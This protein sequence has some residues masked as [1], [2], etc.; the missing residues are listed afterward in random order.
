MIPILDSQRKETGRFYKTMADTILP[1]Y[2]EDLSIDIRSPNDGE[3]KTIPVWRFI[4]RY[5]RITDKKGKFIPFEMKLAQI[6]LYKELCLQKRAGKNMRINILKAR[7]LG[8][9]TFIAALYTVLTLLVPNQSAVIVADLAQHATNIFKKYKFMYYNLPQSIKDTIPLVAS[10]AKEVTVDYGNGQTSSIKI[11][12]ASEDAGRSD[13]CQY[14]HLSE[15]AS[16]KNINETL[17]ALLQVVD[18]TNDNS[19]IIF[20]TTAKGVNEYKYIYDLD[21]S[22]ETA[23]KAVFY[24]WFTDPDY[25]RPYTGFH[26][27]D[28]EKKLVSELGVS[29]EQIAWYRSQYEKARKNLDTLKQEYPSTPLEAFITSGSSVFPMSLV[30]QRKAELL[31]INFPRYEFVWDRKI[32]SEEGDTIRLVNPRLTA[33]DSGLITIFE[34]VKVG[35][36][37][38]VNVDPAMGGEDNFVAQV[39]DNHEHKQVAKLCINHNT[40]YQFIGFQIYCLTNYYNKALLNAECN[41]STGTYILQIANQCGHNFIYQDNSIETLADRYEDKYGYKTTTRNREAM[42]NLT[43]DH[44][45][46]HYQMINDYMT[47]CEMENFQVVRNETSGREKAMATGGSHD[48]HVTAL[49]GIFL[50]RRANIQTTEIIEEDKKQ[51]ISIDELDRLLTERKRENPRK[52]VYQIWD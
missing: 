18:D 43:V 32:V 45:R 22:G 4:E 16:W 21:A 14:L 39:F 25:Q 1:E 17:T 10:N 8:M 49:F 6:E 47:L 36:P 50:A 33:L 20:E 2:D 27:L 5:I 30:Q 15:V 38:I 24:P 29:M 11:V 48:D 44:F 12:V 13:T 34:D 37:Y 35:H 46:D 51:K 9:S 40:N 31:G 52:D 3:I 23:Y 19:I 28:H 41:N 7:Q 42:I 26:L